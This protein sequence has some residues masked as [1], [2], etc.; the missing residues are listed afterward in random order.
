[1][2]LSLHHVSAMDWP[3]IA[4]GFADLT[5]EQS[6]TY[7]Q[8]A[9]A[10]IGARVE[11]LVLEEEGRPVAAAAVRIKTVPGLGRGIAWIA[12]GPLLHPLNSPSPEKGQIAAIL[13]ALRAELSLR[14]G[15]ILRVR[16]AGIAANDGQL[17]AEAAGEIGFTP[18]EQATS[19]ASIAI[20]LKQDRDTLMAALNGKWRTDLRY[21]LKS[22]LTLEVGDTADLVNRFL[23][24]YKEVQGAKGFRPDITPEFHFALSGPDFPR[25]IL[26]AT[27]QGADLSGIVVGVAG[28]TATYLFGATGADGRRL[29]AGYFLTWEGIGWAQSCGL[30]WYDLGGVDSA[31]NPDV[32]RFKARMNGRPILAE[33]FETRL[34]GPVHRLI[35]GLEVMRTRLKRH[36]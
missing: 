7:T 12:S 35:G 36:G 18:T 34:Q 31:A 9:A 29:K 24:L 8:A 1:M 5:F 15:H 21:A 16:P 33:A 6:L 32:A 28:Q 4:S 19:Y 30:R 23:A 13:G 10:R 3:A 22:D 26:I 14:Q 20:D 17:F 11:Y 2:M 25:K 27:K